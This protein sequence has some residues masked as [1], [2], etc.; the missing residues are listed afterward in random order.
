MAKTVKQRQEEAKTRIISYNKLSP[1]KKLELI[2]S[3]RGKSK[4]E[5]SKILK[6]IK[7]NNND[8]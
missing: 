5:E 2:L 8:R 1:A 4:K 6:I 3:R 7:E